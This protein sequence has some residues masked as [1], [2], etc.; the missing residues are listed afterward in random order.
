MNNKQVMLEALEAQLSVKE[1]EVTT[2]TQE[3]FNPQVQDLNDSILEW[4]HQN[5]SF[6]L[7][8]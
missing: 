1:T 8:Q 5:I 3:V 7:M 4:F 6:S 2:Y